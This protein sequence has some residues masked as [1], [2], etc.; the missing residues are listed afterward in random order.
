MSTT[1]RTGHDAIAHA[2]ATG[3]TLHKYADP[4]DGARDV[5]PADNVD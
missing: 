2:A 3:A 1:T 5:T 4:V